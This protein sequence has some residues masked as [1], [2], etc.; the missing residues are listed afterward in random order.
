[1]VSVAVISRTQ[2]ERT[3]AAKERIR[4]T[5]LLLFGENG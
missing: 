5:A 3:E 1:M 4:D 2:E